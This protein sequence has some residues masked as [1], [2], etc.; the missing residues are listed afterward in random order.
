MWRSIRRFFTS[1]NTAS[2]L[3]L[4]LIAL[5]LLAGFFPQFPH[6]SIKTPSDAQWWWGR[7]QERYGLFFPVLKALGLVDISQSILFWGLLLLLLIGATICSLVRIPRRLHP[8]RLGSVS[9]HL[10][11]ILL[12]AGLAISTL[13]RSWMDSPPL[14]P[15]GRF[16]LGQTSLT[17]GKVWVDY[18]P[19]GFPLSFGCELESEGK[20]V[21]LSP[22][23][24]V[25][26][27]GSWVLPLS[28]GPAW[29]IRAARPSGEA[30]RLVWKGV[31]AEGEITVPFPSTG[32]VQ[33][34][35]LPEVEGKLEISVQTQ[36]TFVDFYQKGRLSRRVLV[37][38]EAELTGEEASVRLSPEHYIVLRSVKDSGFWVALAGAVIL[39]VG[40][41]TALFFP[42][43]VAEG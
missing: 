3:L 39:T 1:L 27:R 9:A 26:L 35:A 33:E 16:D 34:I 19:E 22:G 11:L 32:E 23:K 40:F 38:E 18:S 2:I 25:L 42:K 15:G 41:G 29:K 21:R 28:Y 8:A 30:L 37:Q 7:V 10:G 20:T 24:P 5:S 31:E 6:D 13:S 14:V 4:L 12:V 17:V 36:G 43:K